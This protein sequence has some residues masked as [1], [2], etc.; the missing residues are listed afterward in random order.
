MR[1]DIKDEFG[2]HLITRAKGEECRQIII[3][4]LEQGIDL[5][6]T[7]VKHINHSF[8]DEVFGKFVEQHSLYI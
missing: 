1:I 6:F 4:N 8:A 2:P 5:N 7:G 3:D